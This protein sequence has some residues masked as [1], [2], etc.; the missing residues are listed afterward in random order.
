MEVNPLQPLIELLQAK[1]EAAEAAGLQ[2]ETDAEG[3]VVARASAAHLARLAQSAWTGG[4]IH[5]R[6]MERRRTIVFL[7][8]RAATSKRNAELNHNTKYGPKSQGEASA[9]QADA[10]AIERGEHDH[11]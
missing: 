1:V 8:G 6:E 3:R 7:R 5:G 9:R 4:E 11:D 10:G 2:F